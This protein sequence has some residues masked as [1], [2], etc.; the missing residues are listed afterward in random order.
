MEND[1]V[2]IPLEMGVRAKNAHGPVGEN[3]PPLDEYSD[4]NEKTVEKGGILVA[5]MTGLR[6]NPESW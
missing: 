6:R 5:Q 3:G 1:L 4:S 2:Q